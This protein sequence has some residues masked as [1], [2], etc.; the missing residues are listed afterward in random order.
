MFESLKVANMLHKHQRRPTERGLGRAAGNAVSART[1]RIASECFGR[2]VGKLIP[3]AL[4]DVIVVDY[5]PP[6]PMHAAN[7]N[8][9]ILF[10]VSGR[11]R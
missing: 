6:T 3:G 8:G 5:D 2:P 7:I 1:P 10:G 11:C 4:A 9:H